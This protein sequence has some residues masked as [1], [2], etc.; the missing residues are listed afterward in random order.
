MIRSSSGRQENLRY[1]L[2][3]FLVSLAPAKM[4]WH[5][6]TCC[7][8]WNHAETVN[9]WLSNMD[10][11]IDLHQ[12]LSNCLGSCCDMIWLFLSWNNSKML[13]VLTLSISHLFRLLWFILKATLSA[14]PT[15]S[16]FW[17]SARVRSP[18]SL[19]WHKCPSFQSARSL[20]MPGCGDLPPSAEES[21]SWPP[22]CP[23]AENPPNLLV[24]FP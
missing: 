3:V 18:I 11:K 17:C 5:S 19:A 21:I 2:V 9:Y 7:P 15:F 6:F 20:M 24:G 10:I 1:S 14:T 23:I 16:R 4:S 22:D 8:L 12:H 13:S